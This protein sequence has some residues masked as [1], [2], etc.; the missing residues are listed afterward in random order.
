MLK[1]ITDKSSVGHDYCKIYEKYFEPVR[2]ANIKLLEAGI[3]GYEHVDQGGG[4]LQ[5]FAE[6]FSQGEI[7]GFDLHP[8]KLKHHPRVHLFQVSQHDKEALVNTFGNIAPFDVIIDDAS[9]IAPL[10]IATFEILFPM[11]KTGGLYIIEDC[12]VSFWEKHYCGCSDRTNKTQPH[13]HNYIK[14]IN[15]DKFNV[16]YTDEKLI[17]IRK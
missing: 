10:T 7:Y 5:G 14:E 6:Y 8:K 17:I 3:G 16:V 12:H 9:H 13:I 4:D 2:N 1:Y 15:R 11:L